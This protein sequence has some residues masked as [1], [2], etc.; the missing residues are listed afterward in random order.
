MKT[1]RMTIILITLAAAFIMTSCGGGGGVY[2][3]NPQTPAATAGMDGF[4]LINGESGAP[5]LGAASPAVQSNG[6]KSVT[7]VSS[8]ADAAVGAM[9]AGKPAD[10]KIIMV[11]AVVE[12]DYSTNDVKLA[13]TFPNGI[14]G[15]DG[16]PG[17]SCN[18]R[19]AGNGNVK[20]NGNNKVKPQKFIFTI[21]KKDGSIFRGM[22]NGNQLDVENDTGK[23]DDELDS[24]DAL[25]VPRVRGT[26]QVSGNTITLMFKDTAGILNG[27]L[28][29]LNYMRI[30]SR[31]ELCISGKYKIKFDSVTQNTMT[32]NTQPPQGASG[33]V[34]YTSWYVPEKAFDGD[35]H[36]WW[37]GAPGLAS[38]NLYYGFAAPQ[39]IDTL[40]INFWGVDYVPATVNVW[41]SVD[42]YHWIRAGRMAQGSSKPSIQ[43]NAT[44]QYVWIQM[45]GT[46]TIGYVIIREVE[47]T[48][49]V[50][51]LGAYAAPGANDDYYF[52]SNM[53]DGNVNTQWAGKVGAAAWDV[54]YHFKAPRSIGQ[55]TVMLFN[56]NYRSP[57]MTLL[58]SNDG[59]NWDNL[60]PLGPGAS[61]SLFVGAREVSYVWLQMR[62]A[63]ASGFPVIGEIT[64][65]YPLGASGGPNE[66][67]VPWPASNAFDS[68][69]NTW[70]VGKQLQTEWNLFYKY[71]AP[72]ALSTITIN[73][74]S[75]KHAPV[76]TNLFT[77]S[78]GTKWTQAATFPAGA[79]P[80]VTLNASVK[81][82]RFQMLGTPAVG[83]P[84]VKDIRLA[85]SAI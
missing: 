2:S 43:I 71:N 10:S 28:D 70:W 62:G 20:D 72:T 33:G 63:P 51:H 29:D 83:Y 7:R 69:M 82:L 24:Y 68:N 23:T 36:S 78:D 5:Q 26:V 27:T 64:M 30:V 74:Y 77:S 45:I 56:I 60:G 19:Q 55:F 57:E 40:A 50:N 22:T 67:A 65:D 80:Q 79:T 52:P 85:T 73:Y 35:Y 61:P 42:G 4:Q 17:N 47:W 75:V 9:A 25:D 81:Y 32:T 31:N 66:N 16:A 11:D 13:L 53:F 41:T 18:V 44:V 58:V 49:F 21:Y 59:V 46:P 14:P 48:P 37:A 54:Y 6:M 39:R 76:T 3:N 12:F 84:L 8:T 1:A 15:A 34:S 38:W